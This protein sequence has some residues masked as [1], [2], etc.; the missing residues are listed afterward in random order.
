[1]S[2][3]RELAPIGVV[4]S[5]FVRSEGTPIQPAFAAGAEGEIV[6]DVR[7]V[8]ALTDL[9]GF[10]R[11]WVLY[12]FD[13][14]GAYR[15]LVV[16]YMDS[17][18]RGLFATRAPSRP[19]PIGMSC[20]RLLGVDGAILR[21]ADVDMLDGTPVLDVKPYVPAFDAFPA[22]RADWLDARRDGTGGS[23]DGRFAQPPR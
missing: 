20:L 13:R 18:E 3:P 2:A 7:W 23:A 14:A 21:V 10:E 22:A 1:M 5:P 12:L 19:N 17:R 4:R 8:P 9:S 11:V 16:P 6:L 15:P